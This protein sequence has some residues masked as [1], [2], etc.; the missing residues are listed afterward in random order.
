MDQGEKITLI[1]PKGSPASW[2]KHDPKIPKPFQGL[3]GVVLGWVDV[4]RAARCVLTPPALAQDPQSVAEEEVW[5]EVRLPDHLP[6]HGEDLYPRSHP[7]VLPARTA[8]RRPHRGTR[9]CAPS[10]R[11]LF[12]PSPAGCCPKTHPAPCPLPFGDVTSAVGL[13]P[14]HPTHAPSSKA[15]S[16][17]GVSLAGG[18]LP[19]AFAA[20]RWRGGFSG[21]FRGVFRGALRLQR[22][23]KGLGVILGWG[24]CHLGAEAARCSPG[25]S[26]VPQR[27]DAG[28]GLERC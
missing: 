17:L 28:K 22:R 20:C 10:C 23:P 1:A 16:Q 11:T 14:E 5:G 26:P 25:P 4:V 9:L 27:E 2:R 19:P 7:G 6:Q 18:P 8:R 15:S 13:F 12:L 3:L 21:G 24:C